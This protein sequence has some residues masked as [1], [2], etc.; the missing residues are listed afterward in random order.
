MTQV[1]FWKIKKKLSERVD[2]FIHGR[3]KR[4]LLYLPRRHDGCRKST[5]FWEVASGN[6]SYKLQKRKHLCPR[7]ASRKAK[8]EEGTFFL[9]FF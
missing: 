6:V 8:I 7:K 1:L 5:F 3:T 2:V 9:F 4:T